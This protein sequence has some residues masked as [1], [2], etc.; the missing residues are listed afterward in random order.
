MNNT[1]YTKLNIRKNT[2]TSKYPLFYKNLSSFFYTISSICQGMLTTVKSST[3]INTARSVKSTISTES[4]HKR[5]KDKDD[6]RS[7][8]TGSGA[9]KTNVMP[10]AAVATERK[11]AGD[12]PGYFQFTISLYLP[13]YTR[14]WILTNP[15]ILC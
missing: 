5:S 2:S 14:L 4:R 11:G 1:T 15:Y 3:D 12:T 9:I 13:M 10:M 6:E 8:S 7:V